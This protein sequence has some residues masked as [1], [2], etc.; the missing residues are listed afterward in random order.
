MNSDIVLETPRQSQCVSKI[1]ST[2]IIFAVFDVCCR[3]YKL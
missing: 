2:F 3:R 1:I